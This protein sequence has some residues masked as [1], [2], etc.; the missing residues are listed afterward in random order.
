MIFSTNGN[1]VITAARRM[2]IDGADGE[3][4][5]ELEQRDLEVRPEEVSKWWNSAEPIA[6]GVRQDVRLDIWNARTA[7]LGAADDDDRHQR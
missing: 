6:L 4:D 2:P 5:A 7:D 3:A 1:W